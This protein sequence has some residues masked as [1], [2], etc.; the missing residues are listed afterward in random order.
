M[1][2]ITTFG[3]FRGRTVVVI[4]IGVFALSTAILVSGFIGFIDSRKSQNVT[5]IC[6]HCS[7]RLINWIHI[8]IITAIKNDDRVKNLI[9]VHT[10]ELQFFGLI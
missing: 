7:I 1:Y 6:P 9:P 2:P 10:V 3:Q 4:G 5:F 8:K